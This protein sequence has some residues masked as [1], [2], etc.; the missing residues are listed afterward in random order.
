[1]KCVFMNI[2][3]IEFV[4]LVYLCMFE[5][6]IL[7]LEYDEYIVVELIGSEIDVEIFDECICI[8]IDLEFEEF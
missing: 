4:D 1:M 5:N 2:D 6:S 3:I 8:Y 7:N